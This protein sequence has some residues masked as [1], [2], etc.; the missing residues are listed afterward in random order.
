MLMELLNCCHWKEDFK[1][2]LN[3]KYA[4]AVS[5]FYVVESTGGNLFSDKTALIKFVNTVT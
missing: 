1:Q 3:Q 5:Q 4:T 2:Q